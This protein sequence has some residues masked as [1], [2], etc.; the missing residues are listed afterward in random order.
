MEPPG[1]SAASAFFSPCQLPRL[2]CLR[3]FYRGTCDESDELLRSVG[4]SPVHCRSHSLRR[5]R[6]EADLTHNGK[7][8][9]PIPET[10]RDGEACLGKRWQLCTAGG[11]RVIS[12]GVEGCR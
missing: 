8:T 10:A 1:C 2:L 6:G 3:N 5:G 12:T 9:L 7:C 4:G 11:R